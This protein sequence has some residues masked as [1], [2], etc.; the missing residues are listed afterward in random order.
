M[1]GAMPR[2][3]RQ[4]VR[5]ASLAIVIGA[6]AV[7]GGYWYHQRL[8]RRF[9]AVVEGRLYR[10]GTVTPAQLARLRDEYGIRRVVSLLNPSAEV[11][12]TER[13]AAARLGL[14][15]HN[16]PLTGDGAST[17][18]DR[19]RILALLSDAHAPP[20]LVHCA[21]GVNRTGLAVGLYRLR[22]QDWTLD[23]VFAEMKSFGFEDE[24]QHENLRAALAEAA[25]LTVQTGSA[26]H[27]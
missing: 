9:A 2:T 15:W 14:E 24:P 3:A 21:A 17:A 19:A 23:R 13:E 8:P 4:R 16:V 20:T 25:G 5:L 10:S 27:R 11:T 18:A 12:N 22:C 1:K 6:A 7:A 26:P